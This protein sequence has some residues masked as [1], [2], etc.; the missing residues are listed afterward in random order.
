MR[1]AGRRGGHFGIEQARRPA[2][3]VDRPPADVVGQA[4][5]TDRRMP[6]QSPNFSERCAFRMALGAKTGDGTGLAVGEFV[7]QMTDAGGQ[8]LVVLRDEERPAFQYQDA[9]VAGPVVG[10]QLLGDCGAE[11]T[12]ADDDDVER[13]GIAA[14]AAFGSAG[15]RLVEGVA[16]V[17]AEDVPGENGRG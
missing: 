10:E 14:A 9:V 6:G 3:P 5:K 13:A 1:G 4:G 15:E 16:Q 12:A 2:A 8:V 7:A 17:T 11:G